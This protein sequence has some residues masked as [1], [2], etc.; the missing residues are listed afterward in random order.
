MRVGVEVGGTFT[1]LVAIGPDGIQVTK[2]PSTPRSP[3]EG[4]YN[5]LLTAELDLGR[6]DDLAH[7]ST[8]ATNAVLERKGARVAFVTT[9]GFRDVLLM[10]RHNRRRIYDLRYKKPA[11]VVDRA[12]SFEVD[13]RILADGEIDRPLDEKAVVADLIPRLRDG[14][15]EAVAVCLINGYANP[16]HELRVAHLVQQHCQ[17]FMVQCSHRVSR[18]FREFER[19]STASLSA[20]LQPVI[21]RY[22]TR[23]DK[24]LRNNGFKGRFSVMQSNG[25]RLPA[26]G[27]RRSAISALLSGPAAGVM[28]A[29]RQAG[30]S[31]YTNLLTLDMGGT[32]TDVCLVDDGRPEIASQTEVDGLLIRTPVIDISTVGAGGSSIVWID[33]GGMLRV[34]PESAGAD[35]GPACYGRGGERPTV[36]DAHLVRGTMR[37]EAFL[38][39]RMNVDAERAAAALRPVA[40]RL[41]MSIAEAADSAIQ[42]ANGNIVRAMQLV[43]TERG[44]DP[45]DYA[46]VAF[47][48]AGPLHA[49]RLAEGLGLRSI[50]IPPNAGVMSAYGLLASD[51]LQFESVTNRM[52]LEEHALPRIRTTYGEMA[53]RARERFRE[54]G[55]T[56]E[57]AYELTAEMRFVGQ[58]FEVPV[59]LRPEELDGLTTEEL[60]KRFEQAHER[61]FFHGASKRPIELVAFRLGVTAPLDAVPRLEEDRA[62]EISGGGMV[63]IFEQ[64]EQRAV[65]L[66]SRAEFT[67]GTGMQGPQ[68]LE[69]VTSTIYVPEGW[70]V[71]VDDES[72][73]ILERAR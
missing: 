15:Y 33:D 37:P 54:L 4:A 23:F 25:G 30:R 28:G 48:G 35:P 9:R 41:G 49:A 43:S 65:K 55:F 11:P 2:V 50:V 6:I 19:A 60:R 58:A 44:K 3:D 72:N 8:V 56:G 57:L 45:R 38:G 1:D 32:S 52:P 59:P 20:Y 69:D 71:R 40:E 27:I 24:R 46:L 47:G 63:T 36:T 67:K 53:E 12:D 66:R 10:Q 21:D 68:I 7:G 26:E 61:M 73:L 5:A 34:G 31:G 70:T 64:R 29:V 51:F 42:V 16:D 14:D 22:L 17:H 62:A 39:G 13:E 18:E